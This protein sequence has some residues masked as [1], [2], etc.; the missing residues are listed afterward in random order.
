MFGSNSP[1]RGRARRPAHDRV[2]LGIAISKTIHHLIFNTD[3]HDRS[4]APPR[5]RAHPCL[6]TVPIMRHSRPRPAAFNVRLRP[7]TAELAW[8]GGDRPTDR[9]TTP[10]ALSRPVSDCD[11]ARALP[12]RPRGRRPFLPARRRP[13]RGPRTPR[14]RH[15]MGACEAAATTRAFAAAAPHCTTTHT[16]TR[17]SGGAGPAPGEPMP[18]PEFAAALAGPAGGR[19]L[20]A[21]LLASRS[22]DNAESLTI[23][24]QRQ[25]TVLRTH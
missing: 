2:G 10:A 25:S 6:F 19:A 4:L 23:T 17:T 3:V 11:A 7:R 24:G 21:G 5:P 20:A 14:H 1:A 22:K 9:S 15:G 16:T 13:G 12:P 8:E 18:R